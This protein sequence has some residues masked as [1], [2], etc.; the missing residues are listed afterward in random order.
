LKG[1]QNKGSQEHGRHDDAVHCTFKP[2]KS[3]QAKKAL[4]QAGYDF[5]LE[6]G[7]TVSVLVFLL[8]YQHHSFVGNSINLLL[9]VI[10]VPFTTRM[11]QHETKRREELEYRRALEE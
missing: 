6:E 8:R 3:T 2:Q 5:L 1:Q 7:T 10:Q 11:H 9:N 4:A